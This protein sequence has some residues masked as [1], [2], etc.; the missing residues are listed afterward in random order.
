MYKFV[1]KTLLQNLLTKT[2]LH[3]EIATDGLKHF[4]QFELCVDTVVVDEAGCVPEYAIPQ[5]LALLPTNMVL[6]GDHKQV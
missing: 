4:L 2:L 1:C 3:K 6:L 5:L